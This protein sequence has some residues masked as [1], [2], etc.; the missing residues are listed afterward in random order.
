MVNRAL[1]LL[2]LSERDSESINELAKVVL[3]HVGTLVMKWKESGSNLPQN[4]TNRAGKSGSLLVAR[5]YTH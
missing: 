2:N 5:V 4:P 1:N 3:I